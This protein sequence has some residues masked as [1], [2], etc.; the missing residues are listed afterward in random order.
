VTSPVDLPAGGRPSAPDRRVERA[1]ARQL[2]ADCDRRLAR[3]RAAL[4]AGTDA[5]VVGQWIAEVTAARQAAEASLH[6]LDAAPEPLSP[7]AMRGALEEVG[8]LA[9][10]LDG[11]GPVLRA[12]L[13][14]HIRGDPF[15]LVHQETAC[16]SAGDI[17]L[18]DVARDSAEEAYG[19]FA[20]ATSVWRLPGAG[21]AHTASAGGQRG[22]G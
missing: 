14:Q 6:Q 1:A 18:A 2:L 22:L 12:Q 16:S 21:P 7:E 8:G 9:A 3:Y 20:A 15:K 5:A 17:D 13:Y 10:A 4:E 11:A 19:R